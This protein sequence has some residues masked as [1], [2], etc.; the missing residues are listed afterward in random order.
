MMT[1]MATMA[2]TATTAIRIVLVDDHRIVRRGLRSFL[3][4]Q[5]D[6][7][8]IGEASSGEELLA[9]LADGTWSPEVVLMDLLMPGGI[10]GIATT[11]RVRE[12]AP[13]MRV[14]VLTSYADDARVIAALRAGATGYVLKESEPELLVDAVRAAAQ[15]R[16]VLDPAIATTVV[17]GLN[18]PAAGRG[19]A[20]TNRELAVLH[21]LARG[22]LNKEIADQLN[23]GEETVKTHVGN[24][25][26]KLGVS[27][28]TE[29]AVYALRQ[30]HE[31]LDDE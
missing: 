26:A 2:A 15:G 13:A 28:R 8:V 1:A 14:V 22:L 3:G 25:L 27:H 24:I 29:A 21:L 10:D 16:S 31:P 17:Q 12:I 19:A 9:H 11:R 23:I 20:L 5:P 30:R 4:S 18:P 6:L 7:L